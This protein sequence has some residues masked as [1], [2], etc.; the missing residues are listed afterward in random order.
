M[1]EKCPSLERLRSLVDGTLDASELDAVTNHL[2][3]CASCDEQVARLEQSFPRLDVAPLSDP[4]L[5]EEVGPV[6][7]RILQKLSEHGDRPRRPSYFGAFELPTGTHL[8]NYQIDELLARGGMGFV[9]AARHRYLHRRAALKVLPGYAA[10]DELRLARFEREIQLIAQLDHPHLVSALDA[11]RADGVYFY[12]MPLLDGVDLETLVERIGPLPY[13]AACEVV[14]QAA[15]GLCAAHAA[16]VVHRDVKPSNLFATVDCGDAPV[17]KVLDLGLALPIGL[18]ADFA[19]LTESGQLLGTLDYLAPEQAASPDAVDER[20]DVYGLGASFY[21][22]LTGRS[23]HDE[24]RG[25]PLA[26]R[27]HALATCSPAPLAT[28]RGDLPDSL[29]RFVDSLV[30]LAP[31][32]RPGTMRAVADRLAE[33]SRDY[34]GV[35][36]LEDLRP[37][38]AQAASSPRRS[39]MSR[40]PTEPKTTAAGAPLAARRPFW[41]RFAAVVLVASLVVA[42][43]VTSLARI[44]AGAPTT[45]ATSVVDPPTQGDPPPQGGVPRQIEAPRAPEPTLVEEF[46]DDAIFVKNNEWLRGQRGG[47]YY[48]E[49]LRSG[50]G[51]YQWAWPVADHPG[52]GHSRVDV[53]LEAGRGWLV[54]WTN[55]LDRRGFSVWQ[56]DGELWF[57]PSPFY[58]EGGGLTDQLLVPSSPTRG[59]GAVDQLR[60]RL[61]DRRVSV[62]LNDVPCG[63][64]IDLGFSLGA[65]RVCL[66]IAER[67]PGNERTRAEFERVLHFDLSAY[68]PSSLP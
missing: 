14:R 48:V 12:A 24:W 36:G 19:S 59:V 43:V 52:A 31:Q 28:L 4:D 42:A 27:I 6:V 39:S 29:A 1:D 49:H 64:P 62:F 11:G 18:N 60:V 66:G 58:R 13:A 35:A 57:G 16:G 51:Q 40:P 23:P 54:V 68:P 25:A 56:L 17:V 61:E 55:D 32:Q 2:E 26:R 15:E 45:R 20:T 10:D 8:G 5:P 44:P 33:F 34:S 22:L 30:A 65:H 41:P 3:V 46:P 50:P 47:R 53:R 67:G 63:P 38:I 37:R 7:D 9:Y 21:R